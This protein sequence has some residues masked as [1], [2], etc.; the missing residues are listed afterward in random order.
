M[1]NERRERSIRW[2]RWQLES[3][4]RNADHWEKIRE[5]NDCSATQE[6]HAHY[7]QEVDALTDAIAAL[8]AA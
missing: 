4:Q 2:L 7:A 1:N 5:L 6:R 8:G 3:A